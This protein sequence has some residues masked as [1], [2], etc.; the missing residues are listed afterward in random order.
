MHRRR[1]NLLLGAVVLLCGIIHAGCAAD[2]LFMEC[3]LS[4]SIVETCAADS[5]NILFT[6]VVAEHPSC[7]ESIC[8]S[9]LGE[10]AVC[11]QACGS[12]TD[13]PA[14]STCKSHLSLSFCVLDAHVKDTVEIDQT[15]TNE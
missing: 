2:P 1:R 10:D 9:W 7:L 6:C 12:D 5:D 14:G 11:S 3:P 8:A 13:C 4:K 15:P